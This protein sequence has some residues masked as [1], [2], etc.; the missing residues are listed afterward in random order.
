MQ[1][2][3]HND[4]LNDI[5]KN[6]VDLILPKF[7]ENQKSKRGIFGTLI[8]EFIGLAFEGLSTFLHHKRHSTLKK[9]VKAISISTDMHRNKLIHL[10][11]TLIM[12]GIY[13]AETLEKLLKTV[14]ALHDHQLL[15]KS[16]FASPAAVA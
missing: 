12:H 16:L 8:L 1:I 11:N 15:Y 5:L 10:E 7:Y 6:E 2:K 3:S 14:C 13:N 4:I 9:A